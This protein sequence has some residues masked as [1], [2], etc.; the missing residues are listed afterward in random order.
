MPPI[1]KITANY[2]RTAPRLRRHLAGIFLIEIEVENGQTVEDFMF[3]DWATLRFN[4]THALEG[5]TREGQALGTSSFSVSGPRSQEVYI[6]TGSLR[7]WG[8]LIHPAGWASLVGRPAN[9]YANRLVDGMEDPAFARF[10][11]LAETLFGPEPDPM[12]EHKRLTEFFLGLKPFDDPGIA[13]IE[14]VYDALQDPE[15][16]SVTALADRAVLGRRTLER[17]C[18]RAFGFPPKIL[19][20]RQRFMRSLTHFTLDPSLK[21]IGALDGAYHD[22]AQFVRDFRAFMGMTPR[23]YGRREKPV[24]EPVIHERVRFANEGA[25]R[26]AG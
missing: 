8:V 6:Q 21:W 19:L 24:I 12:G 15:I 26:A 11:P 5:S 9:E 22:Q 7:Q 13:A 1:C 4:Q 10:R 14:A 16:D 17:L 2:M 3:P 23:E 20:R 25:G 18:L